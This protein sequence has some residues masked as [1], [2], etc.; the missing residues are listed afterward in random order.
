M[1]F[2]TQLAI[3]ANLR[4]AVQLQQDVQ[5]GLERAS[6]TSAIREAKRQYHRRTWYRWGGF[7][8]GLI[9]I[10][11]IVLIFVSVLSITHKHPLV[12]VP[13]A[14]PTT[15]GQYYTIDCS[16]DTVL[17]NRPCGALIEEIAKGSIDAGGKS[18]VQ[19]EIKE[20]YNIADM[21]R[22]GLLT[23]T[24]GRPLSSGGM[25]DIE[26]VPD[27]AARIVRP[28]NVSLPSHTPDRGKT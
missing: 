13:G 12:I 24:D 6:L 1:A 23:Q 2:E 14:P 16:R 11:I 17:R 26:P 10:L 21:L 9:V 4:E 8:G 18:S 7:G 15:H 25:I 5:A 28:I 3:D 19:L 22:F 27:G 20:A